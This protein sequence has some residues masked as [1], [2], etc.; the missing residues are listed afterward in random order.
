MRLRSLAAVAALAALAVIGVAVAAH[1]PQVDPTTVPT[2]FLVTHN[3]VADVPSKPLR[4][5]ARAEGG[6]DVFVQHV[7]LPAGF[8]TGW[9]THP[10][11][12][13]VTVVGGALTYEDACKRATYGPGTGFVDSGFGHV[14]HAIAGQAG[15]DFYVTYLL[16]HGSTQHLIATPPPGPCRKHGDD[17]E[18]HEEDDD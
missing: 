6:M 8:D 12:A 17:D 15:A 16:P 10:G 18:D 5:I 9:H 1:V 13:I 2:G 14:H 4:R 7:R 11:P 3:Q